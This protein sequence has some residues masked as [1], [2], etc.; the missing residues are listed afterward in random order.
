MVTIEEW[1][2]TQNHVSFALVLSSSILAVL[3]PVS[4]TLWKWL[5]SDVCRAIILLIV[6]LIVRPGTV[7]NNLMGV[8]FL[9]TYSTLATSL[10]EEGFMVGADKKEE[11]KQSP[12]Q[13]GHQPLS[14]RQVAAGSSTSCRKRSIIDEELNRASENES[15]PHQHPTEYPT[16]SAVHHDSPFPLFS[17]AESGGADFDSSFTSSLPNESFGSLT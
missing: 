16:T 6:V 1:I 4:S 14:D 12:E 10:P 13:V 2:A 8:L 5:N 3:R 7:E 15:V 17:A 9:L 11:Q